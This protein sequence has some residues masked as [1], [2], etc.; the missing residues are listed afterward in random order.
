MTPEEELADAFER[1]K[2]WMK[3]HG[4]ELLPENLAL[5]ASEGRLSEVE[6]K[7]GFPLAPELRALWALH[8]GQREDHNGFI[9]G[10]D[11]F[12]TARAIGERDMV[13]IPLEYL[14]RAPDVVPES[15]L[16][17][18]ELA[19]DDW[20]PF[21]GQDSDGLCMNMVSGRVFQIRHDDSPP[22]R[23]AAPSLA[24]WASTYADLVVADGFRVEEGFG[25]YYLAKR[26]RKAE[27]RQE[28]SERK[29]RAE[30]ARRAKL[31]DRELVADA[32]SRGDEDLARE[33]V[34]RALQSPGGRTDDAMSWLFK[35]SP[36]F[37]AATLR[38]MLNRI[39]LSREQWSVVAD[40]GTQLGNN[41]IRDLALARS[42]R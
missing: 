25:D 18:L 11:F 17:D 3:D 20:L 34:E 2:M 5:P 40:G 24:A 6:A 15:D 39:S 12:S 29:G 19:S 30:A 4:A 41:A 9:E 26:D 37:V 31:S 35:A 32:I 27:Q 28:E 10:F 21:A 22:L 7:L 14:R 23:L 8:D 42:K 38:P 33:V 16:T 36:S 13:L 1:I